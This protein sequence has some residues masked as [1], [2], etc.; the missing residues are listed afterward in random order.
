MVSDSLWSCWALAVEAVPACA[1]RIAA[2]SIFSMR[3]RT[4]IVMGDG[5]VGSRLGERVWCF[6]AQSYRPFG[7]AAEYVVVPA[8]QAI[9]LPAG[10]SFEQGASLGIPGITAHRAVHVAGPVEGRVVLVQGGAGAVGQCAVALACQA[11]AEVIA[12]V[13]SECDAAAAWRS[14]A[15]HVVDTGGLDAGRTCLDCRGSCGGRGRS[16]IREGRIAPRGTG[17]A[18]VDP[19]P[20]PR[21]D[22][23]DKSIRPGRQESG[24]RQR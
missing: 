17:D 10:I 14:G 11:G 6:G 12:T 19:R 8:R 23:K 9:P 3:S 20:G 5:I 1:A 24:S 18:R 15:H 16:G 7:T 13:R 21:P 22:L 2:R 4:C